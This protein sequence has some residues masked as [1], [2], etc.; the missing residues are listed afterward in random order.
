MGVIVIYLET[1]QSA[2]AI[3]RSASDKSWRAGDTPG[4]TGKTSGSTSNHYKAVGEKLHLRWERCMFA[5]K[6]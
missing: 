5:W 2:E 4:S 1:C 6:L 3:P